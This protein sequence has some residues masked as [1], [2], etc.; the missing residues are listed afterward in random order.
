MY[1]TIS[2]KIFMTIPEIF[3]GSWI[4]K[5]KKA[6]GKSQLMYIVTINKKKPNR[7]SLTYYPQPFQGTP[8]VLIEFSAPKILFGTSTKMVY[9]IQ[10]VIEAVNKQMSF[11]SF[12]EG[13][14]VGDGTIFRV[15]VCFNHYIGEITP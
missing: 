8:F 6:G 4:R 15:D 5:E 11:L 13:V 2:V 1:D 3:L 9:D 12:F 10:P 14:D 7:V